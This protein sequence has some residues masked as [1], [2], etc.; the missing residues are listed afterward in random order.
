MFISFLI[1][2]CEVDE[3]NYS[4]IPEIEFINTEHYYDIDTN[5]F[6]MDKVKLEFYLVDGDGDIG[7]RADMGWPYVGD[8]SMNFFPTMYVMSNGEFIQDTLLKVKGYTIPYIDAIG[9]DKTLKANI[10]VDFEYSWRNVYPIPLDT[11][12]YSFYVL[13]RA[14]HKSNIANTDTIVFL[15]N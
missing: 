4:I 8:S 5:G 11:I 2:G 15:N 12:M 9:L 10:F 3:N 7:L 1:I 6:S 13:D 14:F